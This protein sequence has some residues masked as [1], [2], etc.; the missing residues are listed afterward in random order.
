MVDS[1][2][3]PRPFEER[4]GT[5]CVRMRYFPSKS[6]EFIFLSAYLSVNVNLDLRNMPKII[7]CWQCFKLTMPV[8]TNLA[9]TSEQH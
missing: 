4:P 3:I 7:F 2:L 9:I 6:R 5:H 1:S 8:V